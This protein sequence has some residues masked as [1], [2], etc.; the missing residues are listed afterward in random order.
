M[1]LRTQHLEK[2]GT[3]TQ[4]IVDGKPC[5]VV[6]GTMSPVYFGLGSGGKILTSVM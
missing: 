1:K 4:F 3:A 2:H 6:L 5:L